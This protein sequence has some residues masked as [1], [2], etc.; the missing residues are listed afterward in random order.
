MKLTYDTNLDEIHSFESYFGRIVKEYD[1]ITIPYVNLGVSEHSLN[2]GEE[3]KYLNKAYMVFEGVVSFEE[4]YS[5]GNTNGL[6]T[7]YF[8]GYDVNK[9]EHREFKIV[10]NR[11]YLKLLEDSKLSAKM[12]IPIEIQNYRSNKDKPEVSE[13]LDLNR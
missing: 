11:A 8:G 1:S 3:L 6:L 2:K 9:G 12:W 5:L 7:L 10:C 13:F 4:S